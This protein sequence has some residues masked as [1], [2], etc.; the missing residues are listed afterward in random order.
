MT[1]LLEKQGKV[2]DQI[3]AV[4]GW[5]LETTLEIA[6]DALCCPPGDVVV[7]HLSG[8]E[9]RRVA[10]CRYPLGERGP[11]PPTP[12]RSRCPRSP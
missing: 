5:D 1:D 7:D 11:C 3:D 9:K 8:G 2:Q 4:N 10:L 12:P 6:M